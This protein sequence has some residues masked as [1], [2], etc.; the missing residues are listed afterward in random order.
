VQDI[1]I[2][3]TGGTSVDI[4]DAV[5]AMN[6]AGRAFFRPVCFLDDNPAR[7]GHYL[8]GVQI[9]GPLERAGELCGCLFINGIGSPNN[10]W[11]RDKLVERLGVGPTQFATVVHPSAS[12][13]EMAS[14]GPGTA[15]LQNVTVSANARVGSHTVVLPNTVI[16]HDCVVGDHSCITGGVCLSGGVV[17]ERCSYI[18][19]NASIIGGVRIH[20]GALVG[21]GSVV[22]ADV[23]SGT[24]VAGNPAKFLRRVQADEAQSR[25]RRGASF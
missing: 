9:C 23:E 19:T 22:L 11:R 17:V 4:L 6:A 16:S 12:V 2:V 21:M 1:V 3:G 7:I 14:I 10:F 20:E 25:E 15:I 8:H 5:R 13:S 24:V 18:G